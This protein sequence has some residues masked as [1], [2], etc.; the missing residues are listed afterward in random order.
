MGACSVEGCEK[1]AVARG[2]CDMHYRRWR[3]NGDPSVGA[4]REVKPCSVE[5]CPNASEARTLCHGHYLALLRRAEWPTRLL[6]D[7]QPRTCAVP[8]CGRGV[9]ARGLCRT[10]LY[11]LERKEDVQA[12]IPIREVEGIGYLKHGY[13]WIPVPSGLRHLTGGEPSAAEHRLVMS[14]FLGRQLA[15]D[16][17]VHHRNGVRTDNRIE[18]L[19]LWSVMQ[20]KGQRIYD[21]VEYA[22][23][24]IRRYRPDLLRWM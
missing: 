9:N 24:L 18:N 4:R 6:S 3:K 8:E 19:E 14:V 22:I 17:V 5:G 1:I 2:M 20:P 23:E 7:R 15:P 11:R 12:N 16:E 13:R 10:H 21:K